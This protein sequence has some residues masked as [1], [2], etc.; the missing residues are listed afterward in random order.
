LAKDWRY[1]YKQEKHAALLKEFEGW[2]EADYIDHILEL[3]EAITALEESKAGGVHK[4]PAEGTKTA[5]EAKDYKQD[6]SYPTKIHFLIHQQQKPLRAEDLHALLLKTDKHY[7]DYNSP[8]NNLNVS[9]ARMVKSKRIRMI[10]LPGV[11]KAYYALPE[12]MDKEGTLK[13][14]FNSFINQF[15]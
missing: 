3:R 2:K 13:E 5:L 8:A 9:L 15:E 12:W 4:A 14:Q 6:W 10:K 11:P 1:K 7:K